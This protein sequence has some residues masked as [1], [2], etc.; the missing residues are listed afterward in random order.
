MFSLPKNLLSSRS[1][2]QKQNILPRKEQ[3]LALQEQNELLQEQIRLLRNG[4][5][6]N[7]RKR[8]KVQTFIKRLNKNHDAI[9]TFLYHPKIPPDNNISE[10][11]IRTAQGNTH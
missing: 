9:L 6:S 4:H 10:R 7:T 1:P 11:S 5:T 3:I 8:K 2:Y